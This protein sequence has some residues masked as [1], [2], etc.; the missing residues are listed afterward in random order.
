MNEL[1]ESHTRSDY[2]EYEK[3]LNDGEVRYD[4]LPN[5]VLKYFQEEF[6]LWKDFF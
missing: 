3:I 4:V 5:K 6:K 2:S 1:E